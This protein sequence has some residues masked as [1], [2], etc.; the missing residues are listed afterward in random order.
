MLLYD[1]RR[2]IVKTEIEVL[3]L[4]C[5]YETN[6]WAIATINLTHLPTYLGTEGYLGKHFGEFASRCLGCLLSCLN[7]PCYVRSLLVVFGYL[8]MLGCFYHP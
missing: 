7:T 3:I 8:G 1:V 4:L 5:F 6:V 2:E